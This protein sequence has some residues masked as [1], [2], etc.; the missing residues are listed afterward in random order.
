MMPKL[1]FAKGV[2]VSLSKSEGTVG[3]PV[4]L[5]AQG[6]PANKSVK[7][8]WNMM[9]GSRVSDNGFAPT[10]RRIEKGEHD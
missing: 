6:L 10:H 9:T 2:T 8:V 4:T 3:Q 7:V 1:T 5:T